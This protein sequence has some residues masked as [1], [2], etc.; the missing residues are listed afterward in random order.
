[1]DDLKSSQLGVYESIVKIFNSVILAV[2]L[3][4][5]VMIL[6][7][8]I[9]ALIIRRKKDFGIQKA[10]GYTTYQLM[11]QISISYFPIIL[12]GAVIGSILG[13]I[14]MNPML[15]LLFRGIGVMKVDF[16][17]PILWVSLMCFGIGVAAYAVSMLLSLRIRKITPYNLI[18]E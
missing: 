18:V 12:I 7:L 14:Y 6:Y 9:K 16:E 11:T 5:I 13:C 10:I 4:L 8:I 15:S 3:L 1:M 2:T 17:I